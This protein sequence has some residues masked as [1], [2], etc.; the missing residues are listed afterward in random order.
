MPDT[1][2]FSGLSGA[3]L[4]VTGGAGFLGS[5]LCRAAVHAGADV[6][7]V[8][9]ESSG[10]RANVADL[11]DDPHFEF[12]AADVAAGLP[13]RGSVDVVLH[14][15][16]TASPVHYLQ[17]PIAT[18]RSGSLGTLHTLELALT[19]SARFVLASTSEV[20]GDPL[21]H[22]QVESYWGNVNPIGARSCYDESKR[23]AEAAVMAFRREHAADAAVARIFN[24]YGPGMRTQDGRVVPAFI[25][26]A[27]RGA[28]LTVAGTGTQTR[29]LCYVSDTI[30]A[31]L[32]LAASD[33]AGPVNIG[34]PHEVTVAE[35]AERVRRAV[36]SESS[37]EHIPLPQDDPARRCPDISEATRLLGWQ[38]K[39][40]LDDG[41]ARTVAWFRGERQPAT[42]SRSAA[43][44]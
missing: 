9:D 1:D 8:D 18:L 28:P 38:P 13:A 17:R 39:V 42:D 15:A 31:L 33:I 22:P 3:R 43:S 36:G 27:L 21:V 7:C 5:H 2:R 24:T 30:D 19:H 34:N 26:Q 25:D 14:L 40:T 35:L 6:V 4:L 11:A 10:D 41:L 32:R 44:H 12:V 16:S 23:F 37:I 20:Y 29:S